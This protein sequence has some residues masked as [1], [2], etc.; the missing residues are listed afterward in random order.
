MHWPATYL[1]FLHDAQLCNLSIVMCCIY[2]DGS[3]WHFNMQAMV[4]FALLL[5]VEG[6]KGGPG[7]VPGGGAPGGI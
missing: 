3:H 5:I 7:L 4:A 2:A 1:P 6:F